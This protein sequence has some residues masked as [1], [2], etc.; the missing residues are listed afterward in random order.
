MTQPIQIIT[1]DVAGAFGSMQEGRDLFD[2]VKSEK[3]LYVVEGA[4]H[5]DLYDRPEPVAKA[6]AKLAPFYRKHL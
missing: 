3:D 1:G 4:T 5:Y 6:I 2:R